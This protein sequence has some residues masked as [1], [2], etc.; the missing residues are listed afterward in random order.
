MKYADGQH[1]ELG[2]VVGF[3]EDKSGVVVCCIGEGGFIEKYPET[4]WSSLPFPKRPVQE[5][6]QKRSS[7]TAT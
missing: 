2:D 4:A 3:G 5:W 1:V 7:S 6:A